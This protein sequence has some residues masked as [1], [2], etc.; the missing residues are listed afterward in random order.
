MHRS[1]GDTIRWKAVNGIT[2]GVIVGI[3]L[4]RQE[5]I[6]YMVKTASGAVIVNEFSVIK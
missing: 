1:I 3:W 6:A 4:T 5:Q 2:S